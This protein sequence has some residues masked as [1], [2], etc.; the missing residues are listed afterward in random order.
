LFFAFCSSG[1]PWS[2]FVLVRVGV[3]FSAC[4]L[5]FPFWEL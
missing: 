3:V 2:F 4:F 1:V 5:F